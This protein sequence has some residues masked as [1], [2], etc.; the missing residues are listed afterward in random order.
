MSMPTF[1]KV[2]LVSD[3]DGTL[4]NMN[5]QVSEKNGAALKQFVKSGGKFTIA[6]GRGIEGVKPLLD[7]L[8]INAPL[9]LLNGA[10][11]Y[12]V[13]KSRILFENTMEEHSEDFVA[14]L[15][16]E[17]SGIGIEVFNRNG[18]NL[19]YKNESTE[20]HRK[21]E[22]YSDKIF[23]INDVPMPWYKVLILWEPKKLIEVEKYLRE[24]A[25]SFN[26]M[27]S[28]TDMIELTSKSSSKGKALE[29]LIS[30]L[31]YSASDVVAIG[32]NM[33][34]LDMIK[35]AGTG[36]AVDN[37]LP[38]LKEAADYC[39]CHHDESAVSEVIGMIK[40]LVKE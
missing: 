26:F 14:E 7:I 35:T 36:I 23:S 18:I 17:F 15:A 20:D 16:E 9:I 29:K 39:C 10:V 5:R 30:Y 27:Y 33:N 40:D 28:A 37:A 19:V 32:D 13:E 31:G 22:P 34:D 25:C 1:K 11:I 24:T 2:L 38:C 4:L 3:L 8:P 12:D 6:T 21:W